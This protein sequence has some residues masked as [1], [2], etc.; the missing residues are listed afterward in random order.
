MDEIELDPEEISTS[1]RQALKD[2]TGIGIT[3]LVPFIAAGVIFGYI[4]GM[5]GAGMLSPFYGVLGLSF[6]TGIVAAQTVSLIVS[7]N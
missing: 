4:I 2:V 7:D 3:D 5:V 6:A 1:Y